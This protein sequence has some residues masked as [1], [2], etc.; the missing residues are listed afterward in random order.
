MFLV[1]CSCAFQHRLGQGV[2]H[3]VAG[4]VAQHKKVGKRG[5]IRQV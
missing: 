3:A 2:Q 5:N 4:A 1:L